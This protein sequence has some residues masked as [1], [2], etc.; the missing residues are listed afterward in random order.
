M[1]RLERLSQYL[2]AFAAFA[3][4]VFVALSAYVSHQTELSGMAQRS[5]DNAL[6]MHIVHVF[7]ILIV[8]LSYFASRAKL[9]VFVQLFAGL[10]IL[11]FSG[12]IYAKYLFNILIW[13]KFTMFGGLSLLI[14]WLLLIIYI[15]RTFPNQRDS[16]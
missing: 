10:G 6:L 8:S 11:L 1:N 15:V 13:S 2:T 14:S 5:I 12:T 16:M 4:F 7:V 3:G 9:T